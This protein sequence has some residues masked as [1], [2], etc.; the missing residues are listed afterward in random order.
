MFVCNTATAAY[1]SGLGKGLPAA[2][3]RWKKRPRAAARPRNPGAG[4]G[5]PARFPPAA[6]LPNGLGALVVSSWAS[7]AHTRVT[8]QNPAASAR[9]WAAQAPRQKSPETYKNRKAPPAA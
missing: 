1:G 9:P 7:V 2:E 5:G 4:S 8:D 6:R 3:A